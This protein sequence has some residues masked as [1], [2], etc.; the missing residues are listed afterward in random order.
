[1]VILDCF[2]VREG[3]IYLMSKRKKKKRTPPPTLIMNSHSVGESTTC[4]VSL[5][6][7][8]GKGVSVYILLP[9]FV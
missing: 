1:M 9:R 4:L 2:D 8:R 7:S 5:G 6:A 3:G